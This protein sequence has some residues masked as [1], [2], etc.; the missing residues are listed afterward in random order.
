MARCGCSGSTCSCL[1]VAGAGIN[2]D[3]SGSSTAPFVISSEACQDPMTGAQ[4]VA[5]RD[6]SGLNPCMT[7]LVTDWV[8]GTGSLPGPNLLLV[9]ATKV[10]EL[11]PQVLVSTPLGISGPDRGTFNWNTLIMNELSDQSG[12]EI[13]DPFAASGTIDSWP[14]GNTGWVGNKM[15]STTFT[16]GYT[17]TAA[18]VAAGYLVL[19]NDLG[20]SAIIDLTGVTSGFL[21][22]NSFEGSPNITSGLSLGISYSRIG[23]G[24]TISNVGTSSIQ[25]NN[26][27]TLQANIAAFGTGPNASISILRGLIDG[28]TAQVSNSGSNTLQLSD[29]QILGQSAVTSNCAGGLNGDQLVSSVL[30]DGVVRFT[31]TVDPG[32]S[33]VAQ[34]LDVNS[35]TVTIADSTGASNA[36]PASHLD[37]SGASTITISSGGSISNSR[38]SANATIVTGAFAH[39]SVI[40]DGQFTVTLTAPNTNRLKNKGFSDT[41]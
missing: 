7:Y 33:R 29:C 18:A 17:V 31:S 38:A 40:V 20:N 9:R 34:G 25:L 35:G 22:S 1:I 4:L 28:L 30:V 36:A 3:G 16:G 10:N 39:T 19:G 6:A 12:N 14:W 21:I 13:S 32:V 15:V 26:A 27:T 24:T 41:I 8:S 11:S 23:A 5:L 2:V 37:V